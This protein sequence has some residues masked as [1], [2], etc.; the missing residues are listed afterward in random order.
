[1]DERVIPEIAEAERQLRR[2]QLHSQDSDSLIDCLSRA[3]DSLDRARAFASPPVKKPPR[4]K[5]DEDIPVPTGPNL[6]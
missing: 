3:Q 4:K 2:A 5:G 6:A 1:V